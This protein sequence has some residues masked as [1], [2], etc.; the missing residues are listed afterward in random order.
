MHDRSSVSHLWGLHAPDLGSVSCRG[1]YLRG[2][3]NPPYLSGKA[4]VVYWTCREPPGA[5]CLEDWLGGGEHQ[6][7]PE[8]T[9]M[10]MHVY[11]HE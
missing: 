1:V 4:T 2:G 11:M 6:V 10:H 9:R 8:A 3:D 5:K 7:G